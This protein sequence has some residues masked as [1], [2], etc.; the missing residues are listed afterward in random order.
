M[1]KVYIEDGASSRL[2]EVLN[3]LKAK[4]VLVVTE[5]NA[6]EHSGAKEKFHA[7]LEPLSTGWFMDFELN[8]KIEDVANGV[9]L[10]RELKPEVV[11]AIGGGS[12]L[13]MGK[14]VAACGP[15][16]GDLNALATGAEKLTAPVLPLIAVPTTSGTGSEA[17]HFAVVYS[18]GQKYSLAD[19]KL[20]PSY[21]LLDPEL[22]YKLPAGPTAASGL[23][24]LC[25]SIESLWATGGTEES[26][27]YAREG[28]A[29]AL[30]SIAKVVQNPD[31]ASRK[32]MA[33]AA[34][35]AGKAINISKTTAPHA[36]S[37]GITTHF[38]LPHGYAVAL[39]LGAFLK[40][41]ANIDDQNC[42]DPRGASYVK[43]RMDEIVQLLGADSPAA[44][45]E[46]FNAVLREIKAPT[47]LSEVGVAEKDL[48]ML[49][50]LVN[51]ERLSNNPARID[52]AGLEDLLRSCL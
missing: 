3:E 27:G 11:V 45:S 7:Q 4:T 37:Y 15:Q 2:T 41:N 5:R 32:A 16:T 42:N 1:Q 18:G 13:D 8:P 34:H 17:T 21:V 10:Y 30:E 47:T 6:Y 14:L 20:L 44:A 40:H 52:Q 49:A 23:D 25:Q 38:K 12:A 24:A 19:D 46:N 28:L 22:T 29:L 33:H 31:A 51:T 9:A 39:T 35:L 48:P 43:A 50:S 36:V 26:C